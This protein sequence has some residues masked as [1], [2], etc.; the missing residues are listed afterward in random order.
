MKT[1][2]ITG[3]D[4]SLLLSLRHNLSEF[5]YKVVI[6][7]NYNALPAA[8]SDH[9][10][11]CVLMDLPTLDK[12]SIR[13][14]SRV[15]KMPYASQLPLVITS[16]RA[17]AEQVADIFDAGADIF[18]AKP[19]TVSELAARL[20]ALLRRREIHQAWHE[21]PTL[22]IDPQQ[23]IVKINDRNV[24]LTPVEFELLSHLAQMDDEYQS[25]RQLLRAVWNYPEGAGDT[26]LVRNHIRNLRFKLEE[27]PERPRLV[28]SL[29]KRGYRIN[30]DVHWIEL[31]TAV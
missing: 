2:L 24:T 22:V 26:A 6:V 4:A 14:C 8:I 18:M 15:R 25:A 12:A 9:K 13:L 7:R 31:S 1:I 30:A 29:P 19:I 17:S 11:E 27:D 28:E 23:R 16:Q 10:P 21:N 5:G 3:D 20:R